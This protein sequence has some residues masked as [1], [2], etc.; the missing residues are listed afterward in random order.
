MLR[1]RLP[2]TDPKSGLRPEMGQ[3]GRKMD[4]V[5]TFQKGGK[6]AEKWENWSK[7]GSKMAIFPIFR[8]FFTPFPGGAK[9]H[10]SS[11]FPISGRRPDLGSVQTNRNCNPKIESSQCANSVLCWHVS[12][13]SEPSPYRNKVSRRGA[14]EETINKKTQK[15]NFQGRVQALTKG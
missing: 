6:M 8:P 3:N 13:L 12:C 15:H 2:C 11:I 14:P 9:I 10:F 4:F 1:S 7:N 5:P